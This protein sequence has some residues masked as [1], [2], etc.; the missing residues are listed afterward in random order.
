MNI[1]VFYNMSNYK[2]KLY[3]FPFILSLFF[4]FIATTVLPGY[5]ADEDAKGTVAVLPFEMHTPGSMAYL[6]DGLRDMLASRLAANGGAMVI[7]RQR[8]NGLLPEPGM[9]QPDLL[10]MELGSRLGADY[11]ITTFRVG[12]LEATSRDTVA[13]DRG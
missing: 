11:V 1:R 7:D 6:Q 9:I 12:G 10:A 5:A 2:E 8:I 4:L 13:S 3:Y